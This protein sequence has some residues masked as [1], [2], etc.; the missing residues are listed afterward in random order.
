MSDYFTAKLLCPDRNVLGITTLGG[1][2]NAKKIIL[3]LFDSV[4]ICAD[5]DATGMLNATKWKR[6]LTS[7]NKSASVFLPPQGKKDI[8]DA[9]VFNLKLAYLK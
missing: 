2:T 8:T 7:Y 3:S 9:F 4:L 5:N 6:F 1:S